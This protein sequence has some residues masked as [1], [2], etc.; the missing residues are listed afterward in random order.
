MLQKQDLIVMGKVLGPVGL[1]GFFRVRS[2]TEREGSLLDYPLWHLH[3]A[4]LDAAW[5]Q[6]DQGRLANNGL[7]AKLKGINDRDSAQYL[8]GAIISINREAL[9][10]LPE[11]GYYWDDL[12]GLSVINRQGCC[13][14]QVRTLMKTGSKDVLVISNKKEVGPDILIPFVALYV[15]EVRLGEGVI[16]VDWQ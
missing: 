13:L 12:V 2:Y 1:K 14:G 11:D 7:Q 15:D 3:H 5:Y 6:L 9:E 10:D 4:G 8:T 16:R